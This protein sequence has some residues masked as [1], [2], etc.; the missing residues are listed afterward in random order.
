MVFDKLL[1]LSAAERVSYTL[2]IFRQWG[3][4]LK[5]TTVVANH[6]GIPV[7]LIG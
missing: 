2:L 7:E 6:K 5:H 1:L 3:L 4:S